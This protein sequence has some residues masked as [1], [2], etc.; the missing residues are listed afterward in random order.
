MGFGHRVLCWGGRFCVLNVSFR[1]GLCQYEEA[2]HLSLLS[3]LF[4]VFICRGV[5]D[6]RI[7]KPTNSGLFLSILFTKEMEEVPGARSPSSLAWLGL[8]S[9]RVEAFCWLAVSEKVLMADFLRWRDLSS[10]A[11]S[12]LYV[13]QEGRG[14]S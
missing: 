5:I 12:V 11:I 3:L 6:I 13:V 4:N 14:I 8:A 10:V 9:P 7:W 2:E 1:W